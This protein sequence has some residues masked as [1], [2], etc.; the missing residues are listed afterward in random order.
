MFGSTPPPVVSNVTVSQQTD[1]SK[2]VNIRDNL[3]DDADGD[4]F[5]VSVQVSSDGGSTWTVTAVSFTGEI[6]AN[7][8]PGTDKYII[9]DCATDLP[10][11]YGTNYKVKIAADDGKTIVS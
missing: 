10:S 11:A 6:G 5:T 1:G 8:S 9:W 3:Y 4:K 2:L 7:I